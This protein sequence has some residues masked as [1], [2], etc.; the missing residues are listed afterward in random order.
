MPADRLPRQR[1][2]TVNT[3]LAATPAGW[4]LAHYEK[5]KNRACDQR[6]SVAVQPLF[7]L[8]SVFDAGEAMRVT[9]SDYGDT[10]R[11]WL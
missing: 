2:N 3:C 11:W 7:T 8:K 10:L 1:T 6:K 5:R 9:G 4:L